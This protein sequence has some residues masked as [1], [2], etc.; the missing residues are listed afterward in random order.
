MERDGGSH[1]ATGPER[2]PR[3][4]SLDRFL[5][6][7]AEVHGGEGAVALLLGLNV[8][9]LLTTYYIIK[10][11]REAL[12]LAGG[13]AE[14]KSYAAAGQ[15]VLLLG[16]VPLYGA[17]ASRLPRRALIRAVTLFFAACMVGFYALGRAGIPVG[18]PFFLWVGIFNLMVIAQFWAMA[19]DLYTPEEGKRL[20]P[21]V[22]F[23][24]SSGAVFGSFLTGR[25]VGAIGVTELLLVS[26][27][28]L[29]TSL[30]VTALAEA[31]H[32]RRRAPGSGRDPIRRQ[33]VRTTAGARSPRPGTPGASA[34][35]PSPSSRRDD[36]PRSATSGGSATSG[37]EP[38]G[39]GSA[40]GLVL[41]S[42]YLLLIALLIL[43]LNWVNTTGEY[44]LGRTV[45]RAAA[46]AVEADPSVTREAFIGRFYSGFFLG[47][48]VAGMLIQ[49]FL[50][51][52]IL[53]YLGVRAALLVLP[54]LALGGY[55]ILAAAPLLSVV[56]WA[57]TAENATDYSLQNTVRNVLFLPTTRQEKYK[58]KQAIDTFFV[59]TGDVLSAAL[60]YAG[61]QWLALG[62]VQ[63][64]AVNLVLAGVWLVL[65]A[66]TGL[67][68][69]RRTAT[70][71]TSAVPAGPAVA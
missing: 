42:R 54:I 15:A 68:H 60:V 14:V 71:R 1:G 23:G 30:G 67:E 40:F 53:K 51:S 61:T 34:P 63:F 13:G 21:I 48:N 17:L 70:L 5:S 59:R 36:P 35:P 31:A 64:A 11:V 38:I 69:R 32:R 16:V 3:K 4:G 49:L 24:A 8:F 18:V 62:T 2:S 43:V 52:R 56:R 29:A 20:F 27:T 41:H 22:A 46:A 19:N 12:I 50:V 57:K 55:A 37:D 6:V 33:D 7:F 45:A 66:W 44:I 26:A 9:V 58:A 47:V 65:A 28:L 10:P 25:L 39:A